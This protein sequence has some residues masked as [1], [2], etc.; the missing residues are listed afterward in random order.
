MLLK[1][2]LELILIVMVAMVAMVLLDKVEMVSV[3]AINHQEEVV[4]GM[5]AVAVFTVVLLVVAQVMSTPHLRQP[6][7]LQVVF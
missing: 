6:I 5:V 4:A 1:P 2:V 7:I 3:V